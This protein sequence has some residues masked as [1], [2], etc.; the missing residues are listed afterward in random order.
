VNTI[1]HQISDEND[2]LLPFYFVIKMPAPQ[3]K[4]IITARNKQGRII[5]STPE[6][7][8]LKN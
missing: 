7:P 5:H 1:R 2:K 4:R 3:Y 6:R 8:S